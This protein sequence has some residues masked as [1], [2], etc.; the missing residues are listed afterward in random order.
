MIAIL[1]NKLEKRRLRDTLETVGRRGR[2][3][4]KLRAFR[5]CFLGRVFGGLVRARLR[6]G[7]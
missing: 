4:G 7:F 2:V 5:D 3:L 6:V 1:Y